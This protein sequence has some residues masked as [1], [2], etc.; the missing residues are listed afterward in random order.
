MTLRRWRESLAPPLLAMVFAA[1]VVIP[2]AAG[3]SRVRTPGGHLSR[4]SAAPVASCRGESAAKTTERSGAIGWYRLDPITDA[5]GWLGGLRLVAGRVGE[6]GVVDIAL[7]AESFASGPRDGRVLVGADDGR[8]STLRLL[9]IARRCAV[10]VHEGEDLVRR[11]VLTPESDAIVELRLDRRSRAD[12]GLWLRPL[13]GS[14]A[15]MILEPFA[16]HDR[17]GRVFSTDLRWS[18]D[19]RRLVVTSCGEA[20]CVVR[21]LEPDSGRTW[22]IDDTGVSAAIA[23]VGDQLVAYGGCPSLPCRIVAWNL[24]HGGVR[25]LARRSG[26]ASVSPANGGVLAYE[27]YTRAGRLALTRLSGAAMGSLELAP[28]VRVVPSESHAL[29]G[30]DPVA[31]TVALA[32]GGR[33]TSARFP[34]SFL[35]V[36]SRRLLPAPE[37]LR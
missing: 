19:G 1:A 16:G 13:G 29:A 17:V 18:T 10:V 3:S 34:V 11:A 9:D 12:L 7:P 22:T 30:L 14:G 37:V 15:S 28:G 31:G 32:P 20:A 35:D 36:A 26:L 4:E 2:A 5:R 27:D 23:L 24:E 21:I 25:V 33:P 6:R 8:V